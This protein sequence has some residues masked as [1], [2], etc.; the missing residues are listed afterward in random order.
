[1]DFSIAAGHWVKIKESNILNKYLYFARELTKKVK[2][3]DN[4]SNNW[5]TWNGL[6]RPSN[7][8][9]RS[10]KTIQTAAVLKSVKLVRI[11]Q[12]IWGVLQSLKLQFALS[13]GF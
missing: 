11:V 12:E 7:E 4:T 9:G 5:S 8:T 2:G 6:Q 3:D 13:T 10:I 1:M